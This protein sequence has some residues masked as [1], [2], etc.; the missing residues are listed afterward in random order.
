[1]TKRDLYHKLQS[2]RNTERG[3][4]PDA[5]FVMRTRENLLVQ[6]KHSLPLS[7]DLMRAKPAFAFQYLF[8]NKAFQIVRAPAIAMFSVVVAIF[9][10]SVFSVSASDRSL[11]GDFLYPIKIAS[12][13]T[14][15]VLTSD[16]TE[17]L[18]LKAE[19]VDRRI[20]E[21]QAI[22]TTEAP[23]K[24]VRLKQ[25]AE[26]LKRDLNT[27]KLQLSEV[28][29]EL[30]AETA[31]AVKM[32]DQKSVKIAEQLKQVKDEAPEEVKESLAEAEM[33]AVHAGVTAVEVLIEAK[34][35]PDTQW[36]VSEADVRDS[37]V[38]KV[39]SI[40][41]TLT[42][43]A[44]KLR[45]VNDSSIL[46]TSQMQATGT[47]DNLLLGM[48]SST[49]D[50][51][52]SASSTLQEARVLLDENKLGEISSKLLEAVKAVAQAETAT[53]QLVASSTQSV[54]PT[55]FQVTSDASSTSTQAVAE[56][57]TTTTSKTTTSTQTTPP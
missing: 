28:K 5:D 30:A 29:S 46:T 3:I 17:K 41:A 19:F 44:D 53:N 6:V 1:M 25:A 38:K 21:I 51:L 37:I 15:L 42:V 23:E 45:N 11:P 24:P 50:Q 48:T 40:T 26:V 49:V 7:A 16:K 2:V 4:V 20:A 52:N 55:V 33:A 43:S 18:K 8:S 13:Q 14:R 56:K 57:S 32:V 36:I 10:G 12:E 34:E 27:V 9:G 31:D 54:L 22:A 35:N 39:E 47:G